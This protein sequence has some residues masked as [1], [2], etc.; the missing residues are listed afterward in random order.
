[1]SNIRYKIAQTEKSFNSDA[2][3]EQ[4]F[5]IKKNAYISHT[6]NGT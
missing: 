2:G 3:T 5:D 1:M 4:I 6:S